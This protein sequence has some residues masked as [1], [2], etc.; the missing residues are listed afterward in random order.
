MFLVDEL[1]SVSRALESNDELHDI[2]WNLPLFRYM[3][4]DIKPLAA[5]PSDINAS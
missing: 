1:F 5:H 2:L 3:T 4:I